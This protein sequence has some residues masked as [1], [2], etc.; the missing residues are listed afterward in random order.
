MPNP[1]VLVNIRITYPSP[2]KAGVKLDPEKVTIY[3]NL[4][5]DSG[6]PKLARKV[7]WEVEGIRPGDRVVVRPKSSVD[8]STKKIIGPPEG[9]ARLEVTN[10]ER[11]I[12]CGVPNFKDH[13]TPPSLPVHWEYEAVAFR[14]SQG[15][16]SHDPIVVIDE[17]P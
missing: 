1:E 11:S 14:G 12:A 15:I 17:D 7:R 10:E 3:Y 5:G 16:G 13:P 9:K 4:N 8:E 6:D 2:E